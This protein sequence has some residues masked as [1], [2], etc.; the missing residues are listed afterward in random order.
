MP[1]KDWQ[2]KYQK[3]ATAEQTSAYEQAKP[4]RH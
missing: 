2:S 1:Y 4:H 3:E